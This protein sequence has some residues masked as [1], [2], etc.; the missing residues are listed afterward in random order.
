MRRA[1]YSIIEG[2]GSTYYGVGAALARI[3]EVILRNQQAI[4]TVCSPM[5][6]V[7]GVHD[8]TVSLPHLIGGQGVLATILPPLEPDELEALQASARTI[9]E[10]IDNLDAQ[11]QPEAGS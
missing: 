2:K 8:V 7:A 11:D 9:R 1:A 5:D 6:D 4:L 3:V 10:A